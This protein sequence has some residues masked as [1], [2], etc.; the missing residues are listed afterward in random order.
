MDQLYAFEARQMALTLDND[1]RAHLEYCL[2]ANV[3]AYVESK[4]KRYGLYRRTTVHNGTSVAQK[5]FG[6]KVKC[7]DTLLRESGK[8]LVSKLPITALSRDETY[9]M[10]LKD[11]L[12]AEWSAYGILVVDNGGQ[13]HKEYYISAFLS[14]AD[15][16]TSIQKIYHKS[17]LELYEDLQ[18]TIKIMPCEDIVCIIIYDFREPFNFK[19]VTN[20][21]SAM[22]ILNISCEWKEA[23]MLA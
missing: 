13:K 16:R 1:L 8:L 10:H 3:S 15:V 22:P 14:V 2:A 4:L 5:T 7:I 20:I 11:I 18:S 17:R 12:K 19:F 21:C 9:E 6:D 23:V